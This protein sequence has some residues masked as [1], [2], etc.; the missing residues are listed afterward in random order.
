M[1]ATAKVGLI[2]LL[3]AGAIFL[4]CIVSPP[5]L[6][7]DVDAVM[8]Q[9]ARNILTSGDWVTARLDGALFLEKPPL[10]YWPMVISYKI[11]GVHD[12]SARLPFALSAVGVA[13]LTAQTRREVTSRGGAQFPAF[14]RLSIPHV[15]QRGQRPSQKVVRVDVLV[16]WESNT[17]V[18]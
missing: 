1:S 6:M 10:Y 13:W 3:V 5:S 12:W 7:D 15:P 16:R 11:L 2:V 17:G 4:G 14:S 9:I 8:A 18:A